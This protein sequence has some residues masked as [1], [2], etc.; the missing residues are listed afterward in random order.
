[1]FI[2]IKIITSSRADC[3]T[4]TDSVIGCTQGLSCL[5][6]LFIKYFFYNYSRV[7]NFADFYSLFSVNALLNA[8]NHVNECIDLI[9]KSLLYYGNSSWYKNTH[10]STC[11]TII[12]VGTSVN[13]T[14]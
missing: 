7:V 9:V 12:I 3:F 1:M 11:L 10:E 8:I 14:M 6:L 2:K 4:T 13:E 5:L